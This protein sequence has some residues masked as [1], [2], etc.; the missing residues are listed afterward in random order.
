MKNLFKAKQE[1]GAGNWVQGDLISYGKYKSIR[2]ELIDS[3]SLPFYTETI[4]NPETIC[5]AIGRTDKNGK[6]V[7]LG[8]KWINEFGFESQIVWGDKLCRVYVHQWKSKK[9]V[10]PIPVPDLSEIEIIGNIHD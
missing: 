3:K 8:D 9:A 1:L 4:I 5:Q 2:T 7:F 6:E 10:A